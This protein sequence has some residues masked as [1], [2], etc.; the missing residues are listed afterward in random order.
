M[1]KMESSTNR[2]IDEF[3]EAMAIGGMRRA[4]EPG[5]DVWPQPVFNAFE[6]IYF[7]HR[8]LLSRLYLLFHLLE[9]KGLTQFDIARLF[10]YP[11]KPAH[12]MHLFFERPA[13]LR[14]V[15]ERTE[16]CWKLL[17]YITILRN[18]NTFC[19]SGRNMVLDDKMVAT[20]LSESSMAT[21]NT[22]PNSDKLREI[23]SKLIVALSNYCELLYF[24]NLSFGREFHGPYDIE[25]HNQLIV[26]EYFDLKPPFWKFTKKMPFGAFKLLT[27][28]PNLGFK[29]D[30]SGRFYTNDI[31]GPRLNQVFIEKD[32]KPFPI[33]IKGLKGIL[34]LIQGVMKEAIEEIAH[35]DKK[36]LMTKFAEGYFWALKPLQDQVNQDWHP[37]QELYKR[38]ETEKADTW[39]IEVY[40]VLA[41]K[42]E[43]E[44]L[45]YMKK[46]RDPRILK[47]K[48][49]I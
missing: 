31:I 28:Y 13:N 35:I 34:E 14:E 41:T 48:D 47:N 4:K 24:A 49:F 38:I 26:R 15:R 9:K 25:K 18:G 2:L 36:K 37:S 20:I 39:L 42:P 32:S 3:C 33:E 5:L 46:I 23:I 12:F 29:F 1:V 21:I 7:V 44:R 45:K 10:I 22:L 11:S 16:V 27:I 8:E 30:F 19:K 6:G 40:K 43:S 17:R